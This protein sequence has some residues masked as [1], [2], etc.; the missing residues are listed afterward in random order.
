MTLATFDRLQKRDFESPVTLNKLRL[1]IRA[2][3]FYG[4][5]SNYLEM[6]KIKRHMTRIES[7]MGYAARLA[8]EVERP[9]T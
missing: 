4:N 2:L 9:P 8:L 3:E 1:C 5:K 7:D 6:D